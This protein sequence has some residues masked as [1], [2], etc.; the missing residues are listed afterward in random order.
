LVGSFLVEFLV[1]TGFE[2]GCCHGGRSVVGIVADAGGGV[3]RGGEVVFVGGLGGGGSSVGGID[4]GDHGG[5]GP[6][7]AVPAFGVEGFGIG[8]GGTLVLPF[9]EG[10]HSGRHCY[11]CLYVVEDWRDVAW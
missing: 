10:A 5:C 9:E 3:G 7:I 4:G 11:C 6:I 1:G 8:D 2:L